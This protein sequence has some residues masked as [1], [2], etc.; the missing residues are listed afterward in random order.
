MASRALGP[1]EL[2]G[3][4][5][6]RDLLL[7]RHRKTGVHAAARLLQPAP[8]SQ[9]RHAVLA[10]ARAIAAVDHRNV[11]RYHAVGELDDGSAYIITEHLSGR[12]LRAALDTGAR[13]GAIPLLSIA[14]L[15]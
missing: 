6:E 3:R 13:F 8:G 14:V 15:V 1:Y 9:F 4:L 2:V 12:T 5:D 11:Q 10:Q 7:A